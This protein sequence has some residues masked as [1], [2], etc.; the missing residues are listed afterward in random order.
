MVL[1]YKSLPLCF[2]VNLVMD[3]I[4]KRPRG[5]A[6]LRYATEEESQSA[7]EGMHGKVCLWEII[8]SIY[9]FEVAYIIIDPSTCKKYVL[10]VNTKLDGSCRT[11]LRSCNMILI[12][13]IVC[14][15]VIS[16]FLR[17]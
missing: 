13:E 2:T 7:I 6:F 8:W 11:A 10:D 1:F 17:F 16:Q 4:A 14:L 3:K 5:F 12:I 15:I 9:Y